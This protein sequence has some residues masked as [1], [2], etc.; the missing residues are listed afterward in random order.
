[1]SLVTLD[2]IRAAAEAMGADVVRTPLLR[3]RWASRPLWLKPESLQP[4]GAF[5]LRGASY[6]ISRLQPDQRRRGVVTHSSGNHAQAIAYAARAAGIESTVVMPR[7][8]A[9][10]KLAATRRLGARVVLVDPELRAQAAQQIAEQE[11]AVLIAAYDDQV[12]ITGQG[13]IGLEIA[14]DLPDVDVVLVPVSGGGLISGVAAAVQGLVPTAKVIGVEPELAGDL[15]EG[16]RRGE[17]VSWPDALTAQTIADGLRVTSVGERNWTHI[18]ALVA[19]VVTVSEAAIRE[20]MRVLA[21]GSR[22]V[23]EPSGAVATA[24]VLEHGE[25]LPA[26]R[27][28]AIVSGGNVD[29]DLLADVLRS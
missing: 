7:Q 5:K 14:E 25:S 27:T 12:V 2:E 21:T 10:V 24:A 22:L 15:A 20:A 19:D 11:G 26:G 23:A 28:V 4:T 8:V 17:R 13:T 16:F 1:M 6:A 9:P 29:P 18:R 3:A